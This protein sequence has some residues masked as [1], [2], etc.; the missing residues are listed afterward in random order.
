[1]LTVAMTPIGTVRSTRTA[2]EDDDWDSVLSSIALD[3]AQFTTEALAG[4]DTFSHIEVVYLFDRVDPAKVEKS[5]RHPRNNTAWPKVGIF[6]QRG[7]NRPNRIG[8]TICRVDRIEG[9]RVHVL[10]LDAVEG[11]PVLDI[12]PWVRE[13]GPRGEVRQPAWMTELM[14][15]YW[16]E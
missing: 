5:A 10:G 13:F 11:T 6:A 4:L 1:M 15:G 9:L 2:T 14:S 8:T 3:A 16:V 7:K 12:K